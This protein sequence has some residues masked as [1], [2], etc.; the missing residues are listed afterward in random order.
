MSDQS[1]R[2]NQFL[3]ETEAD[4]TGLLVE[5]WDLLRYNKKWWLLPILA[6]LLLFALLIGLMST[7][8]APFIY[9]LF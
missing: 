7:G 6:V 2:A 8:V 4:R 9:T 5:F 1:K 3:Q